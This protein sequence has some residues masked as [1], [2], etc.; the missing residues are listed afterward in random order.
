MQRADSIRV[1]FVFSD[2]PSYV[3]YSWNDSFVYLA[4]FC[5]NDF[6]P[7]KTKLAR[8]FVQRSMFLRG[9]TL[10]VRHDLSRR[11]HGRY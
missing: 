6:V 7:R 9:V 2:A 1:S 4:R 10:F 11:T 3:I 8:T 5:D